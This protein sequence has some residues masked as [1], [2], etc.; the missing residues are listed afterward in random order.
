MWKLSDGGVHVQL[1]IEISTQIL[2]FQTA[3]LRGD[4]SR[5]GLW[6][7]W[8]TWEGFVADIRAA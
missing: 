5:A 4:E 6:D 8:E 3:V 1:E 2:V 7:A